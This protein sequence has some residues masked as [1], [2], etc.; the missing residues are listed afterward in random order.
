MIPLKF[1]IATCRILKSRCRFS[2]AL[3]NSYFEWFLKISIHYWNLVIFVKKNLENLHKFLGFQIKII[4]R[5][6]KVGSIAVELSNLDGIFQKHSATLILKGFLKMVINF[7][8]IGI[9]VTKLG[10]CCQNMYPPPWV[11]GTMVGGCGHHQYMGP[12]S[13]TMVS[14]I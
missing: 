1:Y 13:A 2:N 14:Y 7:W 10:K 5:S 9:F 11:H 12:P 6:V 4:C 3:N 8:N